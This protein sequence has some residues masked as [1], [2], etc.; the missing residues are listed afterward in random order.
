MMLIGGHVYGNVTPLL[1]RHPSSRLAGTDPPG[2]LTSGRAGPPVIVVA[3]KAWR[4]QTHSTLAHPARA[5]RGPHPSY[6]PHRPPP[7][8]A[9]SRI[10]SNSTPPLSS[11][12]LV[13]ALVL[14]ATDQRARVDSRRRRRRRI[15][16]LV[17]RQALWTRCRA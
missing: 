11:F 2:N 3:S 9:N 7:S 10:G 1:T 5:A 6:A 17:S 16:E 8:V 12:I 14:V 4:W 15:S 13:L